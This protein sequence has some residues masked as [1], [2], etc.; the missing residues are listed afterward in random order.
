MKKR[1]IR[2][3]G[4]GLIVALLASML[5]M[6]MPASAADPLTWTTE[7]I[8][9]PPNRM[10]MGD[11]VTDFAVGSDGE[12]IWAVPGPLATGN[13][14]FKSTN[15]GAMW[16]DVPTTNG[17]TTGLM[18]SMVA[19]APDNSDYVAIATADASAV[20]ITTNGGVTWSDLGN[21]KDAGGAA[22]ATITDLALSAEA[23]GKNCIAV[24]GT[25][26]LTVANIWY[27][28]LG[29]GGVWKETNPEDLSANQVT[30]AWAVS[31]SPNY[32]SD[33]VLTAVTVNGTSATL[34]NMCSLSGPV[35]SWNNDAGFTGY[36]VTLK[37]TT[38]VPVVATGA[39]ISLVP[40]YLGSDDIER[41]AFVGIQEGTTADAGVYRLKNLECKQIKTDAQIYSVAYDGTSLLAGTE[42]GNTVWRSSNALDTAPDFYPSAATKSPGGAGT[43]KTVVGWA[44][45]SA[46]AT[47]LGDEGAFSVSVD[48][49][50]AFNDISL[51]K[52]SIADIQDV[53][54]A[55]DG[56]K[57]YLLTDDGEDTSLWRNASSWQRVLSIANN[58]EYIVRADPNDP[59]VVY[60]GDTAGATTLYYSKDG[61][62]TKWHN[63]ASVQVA[64]LA[65][66]SQ[67]VAYYARGAAI[68]KTFNGGFTWKPPADTE[69]IAGDVFSIKSLDEDLLIVG[70]ESGYVSYSTDGNASWNKIPQVVGGGGNTVITATG[71]S[72]DDSI[73][74]STAASGSSVYRWKVGQAPSIPWKNIL[75]PGPATYGINS[76]VL[77]AGALYACSA[78]TAAG[79]VL[80][81]LGPTT[82]DSMVNPVIMGWSSTGPGATISNLNVS[83]SAQYAAS[84]TTLTWW[85]A[86]G[87][88]LYS[89]QDVLAVAAAAPALVAPPDATVV[90]L[91]PISGGV[92][93]VPLTWSHIPFATLYDIFIAYDPGFLQSVQGPQQ[94]GSV[95]LPT[96]T[97]NAPGS[98]FTPGTTYYWRA[99][100][101]NAGP[102]TSPFSAT[103]SFTV[104]ATPAIAPDIGSPV[105]GSTIT[106]ANPAFSWSP[107]AGASKY[108]FQLAVG[109]NFG[110]ALFSASQAETGIR[111]TVKLDQGM[112]YFWRVRAIE[113]MI[114]DWSTI[115]NFTVAEPEA[116]APPP[117]VVEQVPPPQINIPAAPP[118]T[119]IQ[120]PE[121]P[122]PPAQIAPGYIWAV[123]IIGAVLV[124]AVI[125]LIVRTRR[126]V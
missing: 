89:F 83:A 46:V 103:R 109:T 45:T 6:P 107:V 50:K 43:T 20:Y 114:G 15:A 19:I 37:N 33:E 59:D 42:D 104:E 99:R 88:T 125:V 117:V 13:V 121:A 70:S 14:V 54:V 53:V 2:L 116:A 3:S 74:A 90:K 23:A 21:P 52:T 65:V 122:A 77:N 80:R 73:F 30:K 110:S 66:E 94:V 67:D 85:A 17:G 18:P 75:A 124:I 95:G 55:D 25:E 11:N 38:S 111:P 26:N 63:R 106:S 87:A 92:Y 84:D 8:P 118:A 29:I 68:T 120:L 61:G 24:S 108:E 86:S 9:G 31:F 82:P 100:T 64:D 27:Y 7:V 91:N 98:L 60:V 40:T 78:N 113:P 101:N 5:L 12:T 97:Y 28:K 10:L 16:T 71:L 76:M 72:D 35:H 96:V 51:I 81:T 22:C 58:K 41:V 56:S 105:N 123:I 49:G 93:V 79:A 48:D 62:E 34:F 1:I 47:T 44:G 102:L 69:L 112:T 39:S 4:V 126:T 57:V 115:A 32:A 36:P 119:V